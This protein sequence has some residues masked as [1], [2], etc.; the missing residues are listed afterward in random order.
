MSCRYI[1]PEV[2]WLESPYTAEM[3]HYESLEYF[4]TRQLRQELAENICWVVQVSV[5]V[6]TT[7]K[8]AGQISIS[9]E[10]GL[11]AALALEPMKY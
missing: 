6:N 10:S 5:L 2:F 4:C 7:G 1:T 11:S 9:E 8:N 3:I